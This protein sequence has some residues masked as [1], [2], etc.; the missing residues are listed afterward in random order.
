MSS[1]VSSFSE[2][3]FIRYGQCW[4]DGDV[5]LEGMDIQTNDVCFS[6]SSAGDNTLSLLVKNPSRVIVLDPN[7]A[8]LFCLELRIAAYKTLEQLQ[9]LELFG[10]NISNR[11]IELYK[12]CKDELSPAAIAFWDRRL[13]IIKEGIGY[14][15]KFEQYFKLFKDI[16]VPLAHN[17]NT[18]QDLFNTYGKEQLKAFYKDRWDSWNWR[19]LFGLFFSKTVMGWLGRDAAFMKYAEG[20]MADLVFSRM[21]YAITELEPRSNPYMQWIF[22]GNHLTTLPHP[23]R[24]HNFE[25]IRDRLDRIEIQRVSLSEYLKNA[26]DNS[27][28]RFNMSDLCEFMSPKEFLQTL[29]QIVRVG[30]KGG[31]LLYWNTLGRRSRPD[32]YASKLQPLKELANE[33]FAKQRSFFYNSLVLEEFI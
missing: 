10:S 13:S 24:K 29:E 6:I 9:Y 18:I 3:H 8:Q 28:E 31:R 5:L 12:A 22:S 26:P 16:I 1:Q 33:L 14:A 25:I 23:L 2:S 20:N 11:R 19:V 15:G 4:T 27:I 30:K 17:P 21:E 7:P 32:S